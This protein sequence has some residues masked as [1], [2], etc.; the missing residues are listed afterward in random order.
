MKSDRSLWKEIFTFQNITGVVLTG[1]CVFL[2]LI[3]NVSSGMLGRDNAELVVQEPA[4]LCLRYLLFFF[5]EF[6][7]YLYFI[8]KYRKRDS[9]IYLITIILVIC[10]FIMVG[11]NHDF[12]MRASVPALIILMLMCIET[13]E[14]I[15]LDGKKFLLAAYCT[16]L[17]LGAITSFN[18]IHRSVKET[19]W[20][21]T[22]G[23]SVRY[24][25]CDIERQLL[26]YGNFSGGGEV[27]GNLFYKYF[28]K[29]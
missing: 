19:F 26:R 25:E 9:L 21:V 13:L 17:L 3:G 10:P 14:K 22:N 18:E 16:V 2:Y 24:P 28:A 1:G 7:I 15:R 4:A 12:C 11:D 5:L 29:K 6:G 23:E 8:C 20:R 27:S